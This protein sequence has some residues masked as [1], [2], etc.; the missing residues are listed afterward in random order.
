MIS[1]GSELVGVF[2]ERDLLQRVLGPGIDPSQSIRTVMTPDP[3]TIKTDDWIQTA[4]L[5][6]GENDCRHLPV[7][8]V[9]D[10]RPVGILSV[11]RI[12]HYLVQ[13][14]PRA[15]YTLPPDPNHSQRVREGA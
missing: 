3:V 4:I 6:M 15:I 5:R 9:R 10:S 11:K 2:T 1:E 14:F 13:H 8:D 7:L 12:V